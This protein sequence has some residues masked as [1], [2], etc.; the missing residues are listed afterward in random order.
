[1]LGLSLLFL[2]AGVLASCGGKGGDNTDSSSEEATLPAEKFMEP[3]AYK[4]NHYYMKDLDGCIKR[5]G[6]TQYK[7][8]EL[9]CDWSGTGILFKVYTEGETMVVGYHTNYDTYFTNRPAP[10]YGA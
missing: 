1:M 10:G 7:D 6:R 2:L 8:N 5:L 4:E 3:V 9:T